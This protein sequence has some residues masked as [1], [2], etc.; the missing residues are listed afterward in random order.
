MKD[1]AGVAGGVLGMLSVCCRRGTGWPQSVGSSQACGL[2]V[3][4]RGDASEGVGVLAGVVGAEQELTGIQF[5]ADVG[6]RPTGVAAV[7]C[8]EDGD[9]D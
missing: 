5:H 4:R 8:G 2:V 9:F 7:L 6:L 3:D 1:P